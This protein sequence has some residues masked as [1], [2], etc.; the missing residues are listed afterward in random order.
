MTTAPFGCSLCR[1]WLAVCLIAL[2]AAPARAALLDETPEPIEV[3]MPDP[4]PKPPDFDK[5]V[6]YTVSSTRN[7]Y[8]L[9][10][11]S[12]AIVEQFAVRF[13]VVITSQSG[14]RNVSH[15]AFRCDRL[16]Y[17]LLAIGRLDGTWVPTRS[18]GWQPVRKNDPAHPAQM[19]LYAALCSGGIATPKVD[20][21]IERLTTPPSRF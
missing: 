5:L 19:Q 10:P 11:A 20:R 9:D 15:E 6:E 16:E 2:A 8:A 1:A 3:T 12:I 4:P 7:R 13:T 18:A 21:V 14:V 17:K